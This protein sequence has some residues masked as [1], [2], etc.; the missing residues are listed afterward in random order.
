VYEDKNL[1]VSIGARLAITRN[2]LGMSQ[3]AM[4]D[5]LGLSPR[6]YHSYERGTRAMPVEPLVKM[7][8]KFEVDLNWILLGL[9]AARV[10]H[11]L[12]AL[13]EFEVLLDGLLVERKLI[14]RG[15]KRAAI[16]ERWYKSLIEGNEMPL[17][18]IRNW[19][20]LMA[21]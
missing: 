6:A 13:K 10:E 19:I 11:D 16:V 18:E 9:K 1:L 14:L 5:A 21:D 4:A 8:S 17:A 15:E 20:D 3:A 12:S 2:E 7:N